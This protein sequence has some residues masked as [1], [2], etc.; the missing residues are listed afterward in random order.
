MLAQFQKN[1]P[2]VYE[3]YLENLRMLRVFLVWEFIYLTSCKSLFAMEKNR[4]K[5]ASQ[6]ALCALWLNHTTYARGLLE[7]L[8]YDQDPKP[9]NGCDG[10]RSG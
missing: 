10:F 9:D 5:K 7:I 6:K 3:D 1:N 4:D 8:D 2:G